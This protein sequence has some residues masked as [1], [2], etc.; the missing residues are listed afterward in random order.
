MRTILAKA[1]GV[2]AL[3]LA[4]GLSGAAW[5]GGSLSY[6]GV[7]A[8]SSDGPP[9]KAVAALDCPARQGELTRT[10]R[11]VDGRSCDYQGDDG[12]LVH[13][14]LLALDGRSA[15][16]AVAPTKA[17]LHALAP[18][19]NRRVAAVDKGEPGDRA[20]IDL[21][22]FHVHTVGEH[23][24]VRMFGVKVHA[25]GDNAD[26]NVGRGHKHTVVHAGADG[27]EV[28]AEDVGRT[29][30]ALV[31]VLAGEKR[32]A[33]GY[34]TVGYVAKGPVKGPL[35]MG[36]FRTLHKRS[37]RDGDH[38]DIGRLIDRNVKG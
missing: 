12:E 10:N 37:G 21:P 7:A 16:D 38:N 35:V 20:D 33:S 17:A 15:V 2:S 25:D 24:D 30:A 19:Y 36:E 27:A 34:W 23:A 32:A 8:V 26:V 5:A 4:A 22:F 31:Y 3:A 13:L 14:K 18:V 28:I 6:N 29:N 11:A 1:L 9:L